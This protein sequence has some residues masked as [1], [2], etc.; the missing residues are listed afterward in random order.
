MFFF[1]FLFI[2]GLLFF[3]EV[4]LLLGCRILVLLVLEKRYNVIGESNV[5]YFR[6]GFLFCVFF[7]MIL[8]FFWVIEIIFIG[9]EVRNLGNLSGLSNIWYC[10]MDKWVYGYECIVVLLVVW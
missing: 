3:I 9:L 2:L 4:S 6:M 5:C 10:R 7:C 8:M 1:G